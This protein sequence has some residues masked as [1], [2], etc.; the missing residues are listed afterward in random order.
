M[1][2]YGFQTPLPDIMIDLWTAVMFSV[3]LGHAIS[4]QHLITTILITCI[5]TCVVYLGRL[6]GGAGVVC[7]NGGGGGGG[8]LKRS[9]GI[10][11]RAKNSDVML[12]SF[13]SL[14]E[15]EKCS[16]EMKERN[17]EDTNNNTSTTTTT[18]TVLK[19]PTCNTPPDSTSGAA[20]TSRDHPNSAN[21]VKSIF[22]NC[23]PK[24]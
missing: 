10:R 14:D 24:N 15:E 23:S 2:I 3:L 18:A 1:T 11:R 21:Q 16:G 22:F 8:S 4:Q 12:I 20:D 6:R 7:R 17:D 5:V 13:K 9:S 19:T